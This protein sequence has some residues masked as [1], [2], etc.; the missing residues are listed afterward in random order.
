[1]KKTS[2]AVFSAAK[3]ISA[4]AAVAAAASIAAVAL[5]FCVN[6]TVLYIVTGILA[7]AVVVCVC[8]LLGLVKKLIRQQETEREAVCQRI[9][10]AAA[11]DMEA[12]VEDAYD[13]EPVDEQTRA[14]LE[15][16]VSELNTQ[17][18]QTDDLGSRLAGTSEDRDEYQ[19]RM[20][21]AQM[22]PGMIERAIRKIGRVA[23]Q[24]RINDIAAFSRNLCDLI[25]SSLQASKKPT[26]LASEL[27]LIRKYLDLDDAITGRRTEY[28]MSVMCSIVGYKLVPHLVLP[29]VE[30]LLEHSERSKDSHYELAIEINADPENV[31]VLIRDNG[32]G[33]DV[34]T[35]ER[36]EKHL[37]TGTVDP[38]GDPLSL[39]NIN[40]R[41]A[42]CYGEQYGLKVS[43]S[44]MGTS[45]KIILP[46]KPD[47]F[48][49]E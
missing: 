24:R 11:G 44:K 4:C 6:T 43:S 13:Y 19:F 3:V 8:S 46:P 1:M 38:E 42:L 18:N 47:P 48:Y 21:G 27:G 41:I 17:K 25:E 28:R 2:N 45:V 37:E 33:I 23:E 15:A 5:G 40:R 31:T 9:R 20:I 10:G 29:V 39:P 22:F 32:R 14:A 16:V 34:D 49:E 12:A 30:N 36:I 26:S 7:A 35:L